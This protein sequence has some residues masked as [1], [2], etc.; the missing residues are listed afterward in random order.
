MPLNISARSNI[1][2]LKGANLRQYT[3]A[4][5]AT[6]Q[7]GDWVICNG[8]DQIAL[9]QGN[10]DATTNPTIGLVVAFETQGALTGTGGMEAS[11]CV[12]GPV[13]GF[14]DMDVTKPVW[15][16][17]AT[18]G[19]STQTKPVGASNRVLVVGKPIR[20]DVL[21]VSVQKFEAAAGA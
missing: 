20:S 13:A 3:V 16:S 1:R 9:G 5:G 4:N 15:L 10:A 2:F 11:V 19:A 7:V 6:I 8:T 21:W 12:E 18:A 17:A 14:R